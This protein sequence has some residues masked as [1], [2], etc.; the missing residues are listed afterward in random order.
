MNPSGPTD[1]AVVHSPCRVR[2]DQSGHDH[3]AEFASDRLE[4]ADRRPAW[5]GLGYVA[6][7]DAVEMLKERVAA[8]RA[9]VKADNLGPLL[10]CRPREIL[11]TRK[12]MSLV[13]IAM[14]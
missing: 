9:L 5:D 7:G 12:A 6:K 3:N 13:V 10:G 14:F 1:V 8:D 11:D 4:C 2:F